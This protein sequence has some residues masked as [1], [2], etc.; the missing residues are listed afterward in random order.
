MT[1]KSDF[2]NRR[3]L[4]LRLLD[5]G[6]ATKQNLVQWTGLSNTTVSDAINA[7]L[8]TGF[9][10]AA[11]MQ[12]SIGGRR[13]VIYSINGE[14]GQFAGVEM[15]SRG[16]R[17]TICDARGQIQSHF[18]VSRHPDELSINLL[19]RAVDMLLER[20][21]AANIL[22]LGIGVEGRIDYP[23]QMVLRSDSLEWKNVPLKEIVERRIYLP[24]FIDSTIN[25]QVSLRK[26]TQGVECPAHFMILNDRFPCKAA[27]C[28]DGRICRGHANQCCA[29]DGFP[30]LVQ[31]VGNIHDL[32]GLDQVWVA[33]RS[34]SQMK[35]VEQMLSRSDR[36]PISLYLSDPAELA[37]GMALDAET[38]WFGTIYSYA[39]NPIYHQQDS[40]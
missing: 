35:E 14:Y 8:S 31:Q 28:L 21:D 30:T 2:R 16:A 23:S 12:K 11:G 34:E 3:L 32:L 25:G 40:P 9:V 4:L 33:C 38:R 39:K 29:A 22:A 26:Y 36:M 37:W 13:S 17:I 27:L 7:M 19:Y 20:P 24:V 5:Y 10:R 18:Q 1:E 6:N 15:W